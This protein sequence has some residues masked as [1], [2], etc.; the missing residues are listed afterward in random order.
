[1][2]HLRKLTHNM[3]KIL[4]LCKIN[5]MADKNENQANIEELLTRIENLGKNLSDEE[6]L[7]FARE[8][9]KIMNE[10]KEVQ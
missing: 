3:I 8:A 2:Q 4:D 9:I 6:K 10:D 1:M 5:D 7:I